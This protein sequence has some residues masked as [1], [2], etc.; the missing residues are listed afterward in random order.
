MTPDCFCETMPEL[1]EASKQSP[2]GGVTGRPRRLRGYLSIPDG[3][4]FYLDEIAVKY[5]GWGDGIVTD[6]LLEIRASTFKEA[7]CE[8]T[9]T[10][11]GESDG[12]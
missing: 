9:A 11:E 6:V 8:E 12:R 3:R 7:G 10:E 5:N 4:R 2:Y 1:A